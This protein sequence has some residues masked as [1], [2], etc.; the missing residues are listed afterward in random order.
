MLNFWNLPRKLRPNI[1]PKEGQ[2]MSK[3]KK[4]KTLNE[5]MKDYSKKILRSFFVVFVVFLA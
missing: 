1:W 5:D 3:S 2:K 4:F